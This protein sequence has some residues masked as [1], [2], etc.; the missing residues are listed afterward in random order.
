MPCR[1]E[2]CGKPCDCGEMYCSQCLPYIMAD[3]VDIRKIS[4]AEVKKI[5]EENKEVS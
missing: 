3:G 1:C 5:V 2:N 4:E